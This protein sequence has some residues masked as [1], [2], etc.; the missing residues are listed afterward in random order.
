MS[1]EEDA[2]ELE[3]IICESV[4]SILYDYEETECNK[5]VFVAVSNNKEIE[6]TFGEVTLKSAKDILKDHPNLIK[7]KGDVYFQIYTKDGDYITD[8]NRNKVCKDIKKELKGAYIVLLRTLSKKESGID[9]GYL[10]TDTYHDEHDKKIIDKKRKHD[11]EISAILL[12]KEKKGCALNVAESIGNVAKISNVAMYA[13]LVAAMEVSRMNSI[14]DCRSIYTEEED[15]S[16]T[17]LMKELT[18]ENKNKEDN[19]KQIKSPKELYNYLNS[20]MVGQDKQKKVISTEIFEH[21][22]RINNLDE[23]IEKGNILITGDTG[24]GKTFIIEKLAEY[25]GLPVYIQDCKALTAAGY[26][27]GNIEDVLEG[28]INST[29]GNIELAEKGIVILDEFDKLKK[30]FDR[31]GGKDVGGEEVQQGLLKILEGTEVK[32]KYD[33]INTK[34]ILFIAIGAFDGIENIVERRLNKG[35][36]L[37]N[38]IGFGAE[39]KSKNDIKK[40]SKDELRKNITRDDI[41]EYGFISEI[42]GRF[43][44]V[45]NFDSLNKEDLIKIMKLKQ[46]LFGSY[47]NEFKILGKELTINDNVYDSIADKSLKLHVGA[48]GL[49]SI[50]KEIMSPILFSIDEQ[51][52]KLELNKEMIN[53]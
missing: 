3:R 35:K 26:M 23:Q 14:D 28:L 36:R 27:G 1:K 24:V 18:G 5:I 11:A 21:Y 8:K 19:I 51:P 34:N 30:Q 33:R 29:N 22:L 53:L 25:L 6:N 40:Y 48:R 7:T 50:V 45:S 9:F 20:V 42:I 12:E 52:D 39:I 32:L 15:D 17:F 47:K 46:G 43:A 10:Y 44:I 41:M 13:V 37:N 49:R 4:D 31:T 38:R 2:K 16:Y